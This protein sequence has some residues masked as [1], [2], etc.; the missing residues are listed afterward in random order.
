MPKEFKSSKLIELFASIEILRKSN[1]FV[2]VFNSN[3]GVFLY[4]LRDN[5]SYFVDL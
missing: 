1:V 2:G 3:P 4:L 5:G